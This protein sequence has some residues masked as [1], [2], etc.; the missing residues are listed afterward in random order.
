MVTSSAVAFAVLLPGLL[1]AHNVADHWAQTSNQAISKALPGWAGRRACA[2]HVA[3]YTA[4]TAFVTAGL[5]LLFALPVSTLGFLAGQAVSA[6]THYWADRRVTLARL[7]A[8]VGKSEFYR[9]GSPR[10]GRDD[11][12]TLGTGAYALDQAW[13]WWWLAVAAVVTVL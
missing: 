4:F 9:L 5:C 13:H 2:A 10:P 8:L 1:V 7:A 11:N 3:V 6:V 12:P